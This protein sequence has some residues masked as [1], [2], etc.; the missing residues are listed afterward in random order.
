MKKGGLAVTLSLYPEGLFY[1]LRHFVFSYKI[2]EQQS[3]PA[4]EDDDDDEEDFLDIVSVDFPDFHRCLDSKHYSDDPNDKAN[5]INCFL[6]VNVYDV[7][8]SVNV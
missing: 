5:H 7:I 3:Y 6:D 2:V 8:Y 4:C 1:P